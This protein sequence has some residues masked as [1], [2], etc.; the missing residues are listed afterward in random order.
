MPLVLFDVMQSALSRL[1]LS[2][3]AAAL[4]VIGIFA[5]SVVNI[6]VYRFTRTEP[7]PEVLLGPFGYFAL[8][9]QVR[10]LRLETIVAVNLGGCVIPA[11]VAAWQLPWVWSEGPACLSRLTMISGG[12]IL[13]CYL[14]ARPVPGVGIMMPGVLS[15]LVSVGLTWLL[16]PDEMTSRVAVA[17]IAGILGPLIGAD[18]LHLRDILRVPVG[19]LSIGGAGTFDGIV[20]SGILSALLA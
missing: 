16:C 20:L 6:P 3:A 2:S 17:Y 13:A 15:P 4:L 7:Q 11:A 12:N 8:E 5:G 18:L 9:P 1:H 10:R 14:A 19:I